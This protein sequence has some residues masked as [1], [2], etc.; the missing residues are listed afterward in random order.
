MSVPNRCFA[1]PRCSTRASRARTTPTTPRVL[2]GL[3][4]S[5]DAQGDYACASEPLYRQA[6][7]IERKTLGENHPIYATQLNNLA[8]LY[9]AQH[10]YAR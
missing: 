8:L 3:R 4:H 9:L 6:L 7:E 5:Y 1:R 10:D 2:I